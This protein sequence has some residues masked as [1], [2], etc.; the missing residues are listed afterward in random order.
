MHKKR[1]IINEFQNINKTYL[2]MGFIASKMKSKQ[3]EN[4]I[5]V[6]KLSNSCQARSYDLEFNFSSHS[7]F[8]IKMFKGIKYQ[9]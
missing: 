8:E 4:G 1:L 5:N 7:H 6:S 9:N 2:C 3:I